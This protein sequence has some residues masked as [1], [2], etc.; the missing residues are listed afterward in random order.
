MDYLLLTKKFLFES[1][2]YIRIE[3][4][5]CCDMLNRQLNYKL[6]RLAFEMEKI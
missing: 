5:N 1:I 4:A 3:E 2:R 6:Q